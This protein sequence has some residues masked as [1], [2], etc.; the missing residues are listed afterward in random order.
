[1]KRPSKPSVLSAAGTTLANR[2]EAWREY[3]Q[4]SKTDAARACGVNR[5]TYTRWENGSGYEPS[6]DSLRFIQAAFGLTN[7]QLGYLITGEQ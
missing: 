4:L 5:V 3:R 7:A 6:C 2:L 1:M